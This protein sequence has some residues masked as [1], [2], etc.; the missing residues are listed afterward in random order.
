MPTHVHPLAISPLLFV[1]LSASRAPTPVINQPTSN[2]QA[3]SCFVRLNKQPAP[4]Y[5]YAIA[6]S[7]V[8]SQTHALGLTILAYDEWINVAG[9]FTQNRTSISRS[10]KKRASRQASHSP[11][12]EEKG[13]C[14]HYA[15][16]PH[17]PKGMFI[18]AAPHYVHNANQC[19][20]I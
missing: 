17:H 10:S 9:Q 15:R 16:L 4:A 19:T 14:L 11:D 20:E 18:L 8:T 1:S 2:G 7:I 6:P 3:L 5:H 13:N 12:E